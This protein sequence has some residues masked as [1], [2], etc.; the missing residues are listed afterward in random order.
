M[1]HSLKVWELVDRPT[2]HRWR[3]MQRPPT[4]VNR[5]CP[6]LTHS[7]PLVSPFG[8]PA[9]VSPAASQLPVVSRLLL[10]GRSAASPVKS[11]SPRR[12]RA[13][14][15]ALVV[16]R[17][18]LV[19]PVTASVRGARSSQTPAH[20]TPVQPL[21]WCAGD[22][23]SAAPSAAKASAAA[24]DPSR[25]LKLL[26]GRAVRTAR[27]RTP[28]PELDLPQRR[29]PRRGQHRRPRPPA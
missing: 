6:A 11:K 7:L 2:P 27:I 9:A 17:R 26:S 5:R 25:R 4:L 16:Q 13:V 12:S 28:N 14:A 23:S 21:P 18:S 22:R 20:A 8:L 3:E 10:M 24:E 15:R 19:W 29:W 1:H